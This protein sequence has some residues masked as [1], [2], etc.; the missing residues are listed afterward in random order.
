MKTP[1][2]L[3]AAT[4]AVGLFY[5]V[6]PFTLDVYRRFRYRKVVTC[7]DIHGLAEVRL[8]ARWAA[9]TAVFNKPALRVKSCTLWP[10]KKGCAEGCVKDNWPSD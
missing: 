10:R 2:I 6:L 3:I 1:L 7:P 9:L 5:I 4:I 8:N